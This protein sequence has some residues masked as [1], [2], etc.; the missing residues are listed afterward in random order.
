M[1]ERPKLSKIGEEIRRWSELIGAELATWPTVTSKP[2]FGLTAFYRGK[3]IFAALPRTRA[4]GTDRSLLIKLPGVA[5]ARL[6]G[7]TGPGAGWMTF[8][9]ETERDITAALK[10]L[11]KAYE[12]A[13]KSRSR[14]R[15]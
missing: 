1:P 6:K 10:W 8:E 2:M 13:G 12:K 15:R 3:R 9:L 14:K 7:P 11:G 4:V 5:D